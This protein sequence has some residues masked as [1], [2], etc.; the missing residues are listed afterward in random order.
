[1]FLSLY[2]LAFAFCL[3]VEGIR[4]RYKG[5]IF[6]ILLYQNFVFQL[7]VSIVYFRMVPGS[8]VVGIYIQIYL[9]L[10]LWD[11]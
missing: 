5:R 9:T 2:F 10:E 1:M 7:N 8:A 11:I 3:F 4:N 6:F